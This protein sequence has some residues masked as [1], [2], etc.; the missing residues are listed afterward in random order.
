MT[1]I[2]AAF[3]PF[4]GRTQNRAQRATRHLVGHPGVEVATLPTSF[5][6]LPAAIDALL[7]RRPEPLVLVGE[8]ARIQ[9]LKVERF[10]VNLAD[11]RI[12]DNDGA[13]PRGVA[14]EPDGPAARAVRF[15]VDEV[16]GAIRLAGVP[17][18]ASAHA[19]TFCCN[20]AFYHALARSTAG[21]I[22][23]FVHLP[24]RRRALR[25]K[26]AA[27]GILRLVEALSAGRA[28]TRV[29]V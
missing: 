22:V 4:A 11:A 24:R 28:Q 19:G 15:P 18:E 2:V 13:R 17:A 26:E 23:A 8:A 16:V 14:I 1:A 20:A 3:E 10:A 25:G 12:P 6:R 9:V 21:P 29:F 27:L 5:A 7:A